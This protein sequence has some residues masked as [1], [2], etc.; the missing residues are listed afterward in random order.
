VLWLLVGGAMVAWGGTSVRRLLGRAAAPVS[1]EFAP[2]LPGALTQQLAELESR[3]DYAPVALWQA[4]D[5]RVEPLNAAARRLLAPGGALEREAFLVRLRD[6]AARAGRLLLAYETE[7]GSERAVLAA[8]VLSIAGREQTLLA[9]MP[10][11]TELE[12]ETLKAWRQLVHVLTHEIMNS[13]T[14]IASLSRSAQEMLGDPDQAEDLALALEAVARRAEALARFVG[15]YRQVSEWPAPRLEPVALQALFDRL[16]QLT[17]AEWRQRGG[18]ATFEVEP[19]TLTLMAD[20]G[21]LE[22]ALLNLI[23]N[24][25]QATC[26]TAQPQLQ[27]LARLGRGGRLAISVRDNGPGV[28]PGLEQQIFTP[29]FSARETPGSGIGLAVVRNLVH[30]MGG[31]VRCVKQPHGACFLLTF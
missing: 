4:A 27:V 6:A 9:L 28:P 30:G 10:I 24:A 21:Q 11:E 8:T 20:P 26:D 18:G 22:Q 5:G 3:L 23:R 7:R 29:F 17:G 13:L 16:Q 15:D 31:T 25:A 2:G 1:A 12:A 19:P 14:P